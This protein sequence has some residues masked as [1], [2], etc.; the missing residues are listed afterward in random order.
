MVL[1][2]PVYRLVGAKVRKYTLIYI[3]EFLEFQRG[4]IF[5]VEKNKIF[6]FRLIR[7]AKASFSVV[8]FGNFNIRF[9]I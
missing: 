1:A 7:K 8:L 6:S 9:G 4:G 5:L 3:E 2:K